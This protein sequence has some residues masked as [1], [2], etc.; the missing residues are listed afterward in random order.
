MPRLKRAQFLAGKSGDDQLLDQL[1]AGRKTA[2]AGL[3]RD[4]H[5]PDGDYDDGG[6][7]VGDL[8]EVYDRLGCLRGHIRITD[9]Y[10]TT[11]GCIPGKLWR[12]EVC[13]S[14]EDFRHGHRKCWADE[15]LTD[16][17]R[18]MA[19]HFDLVEGADHEHAA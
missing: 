10:E 4:R 7:L 13:A 15:V 1:L 3:A 9:V 19:F 12:G 11:F 6:Y 8:V 5:V 16:E 18:I 14:A 17:T 2:S